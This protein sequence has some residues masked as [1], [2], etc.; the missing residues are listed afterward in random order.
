MRS[1][2]EIASPSQNAQ[3]C[4]PHAS[5]GVSHDVRGCF[6]GLLSN[7]PTYETRLFHSGATG[8]FCEKLLLFISQPNGKD[9][10]VSPTTVSIQIRDY[11]YVFCMSTTP[12]RNATFTAWRLTRQRRSCRPSRL[13]DTRVIATGSSSSI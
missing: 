7:E 10:Q 3:S 5:G 13:L 1:R 6:E 9:S 2:G 11:L 8:A 12:P 4:I